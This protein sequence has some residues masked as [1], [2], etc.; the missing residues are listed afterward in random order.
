LSYC[1]GRHGCF[2]HEMVRWC[3]MWLLGVQLFQ[4][5]LVFFWYN[6]LNALLMPCI[7]VLKGQKWGL[8]ISI[9]IMMPKWNYLLR[10]NNFFFI[11]T[12]GT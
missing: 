5:F 1:C 4:L 8:S 2:M 9:Q 12:R 7:L 6:F 11:S 3:G 10:A